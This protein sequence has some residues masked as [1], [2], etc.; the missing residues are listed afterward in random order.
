MSTL[1]HKISVRVPEG[2]GKR[3][4]LAAVQAGVPLGVLLDQL[5]EQRERKIRRM[6]SPLHRVTDDDD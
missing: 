2:F 6:P 1:S 5:L 4:K 3:A